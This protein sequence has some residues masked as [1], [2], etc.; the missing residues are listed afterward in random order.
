[1]TLEPF[2]LNIGRNRSARE[3]LD[4]GLLREALKALSDMTQRYCSLANSGDCGFWEPEKEEQV[5]Q[6]RTVITKLEE[7]LLRE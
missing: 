5:I 4:V 7:R 3:A 2:S 1:M 6:S